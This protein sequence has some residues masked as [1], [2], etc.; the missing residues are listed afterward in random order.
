[1]KKAPVGV[2]VAGAPTATGKS[3]RHT[4]T[5]QCQHVRR[6]STSIAIAVV[7][8]VTSDDRIQPRRRSAHRQLDL[9]PVAPCAPVTRN[10]RAE[11]TPSG[12]RNIGATRRSGG[13]D[14]DPVAE[15]ATT[16]ETGSN[17]DSVAAIR[18]VL[19]PDDLGAP[20][21]RRHDGCGR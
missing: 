13:I 18:E 17:A 7:V 1:M 21:M 15:V 11:S 6:R 10:V 8:V 14:R 5:Q 3:R 9:Q 16:D 4:G 20:A 19:G 12:R 2:G